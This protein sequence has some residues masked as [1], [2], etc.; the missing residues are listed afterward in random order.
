MDNSQHIEQQIAHFKQALERL[1]L[2]HSIGRIGTF[3]RSLQDNSSLWTPELEAI[4]GLNPGEFEGRHESW[5][6]YIH[7]ADRERAAHALEQAIETTGSFETEFRIIRTDQQI[8]WIQAKG[9]V[10]YDEAQQPQRMIGVQIDITERKQTALQL[11]F[12]AALLQAS[13]D[14]LIVQDAQNRVLFWNRGATVL[15]GWS[16]EEVLGQSLAQL[17][18][19]QFPLPLQQIHTLLSHQPFWEGE[20]IQTRRDGTQLTIASRWSQLHELKTGEV[21]YLIINRDISEFKR[22]QTH[23]HF[24]AEASKQLVTAQTYQEALR[25]TVHSAVPSIADWCRIDLLDSHSLFERLTVA[26]P[27]LPEE[28]SSQ[29]PP[30]LETVITTGA[31]RLFPHLSAPQVQELTRTPE[32]ANR[33][34]TQGAVSAM[35]VPFH[36][37]NVPIGILT[38]M[39]TT[40]KRTYTQTDLTMAEELASRIALTLEKVRMIQ[41]A[42][43]LNASLEAQVQH[44]TEALQ[45]SYEQLRQ[46]NI[47]LQQ[48]NQELQ[49]F[50]HVASHDLQEP[51]R[52]ILAFG[53]LLEEECGAKL[54]DGKIYLDRMRSA[55]SRMQRLIND[56][57]AFTGIATKV[58]PF[59]PVD[60]NETAQTVLDLLETRLQETGGQVQLSPL[61]TIEADPIHMQQLLQNLISNALK[62]H[63]PSIPPLVTVSATISGD[64][65]ICT[66]SVSDNGIGFDEKYL[67][68]IFTVFQRLH[69]RTEYEGTGIGLAVVRKIVERHGG[70]IT[71]RSTPGEGTTF[72]VQLPVRQPSTANETELE[73][74]LTTGHLQL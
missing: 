11:E 55:A 57:L 13:Y 50:A 6:Q 68:R 73:P 64:P 43:A 24:L 60:L 61:P 53:D 32:E 38:F 29:L 15:Y 17:L 3:E 41:H 31:S 30:L 26:F 28:T 67:D 66:L 56:L 7:P 37:Q 35:I 16:E 74:D 62:F 51:L 42:R 45:R 58:Q 70:T 19:T 8:R 47:D 23:I 48:S 71:A 36:L 44:R 22:T 54:D 33:L 20:L 9:R 18:Q 12:Q 39:I 40:A 69:G 4:Y 52:K 25:N 65:P 49:E 46:V 72:L 34:R 14:A 1:T 59:T 5:L 10:L 27:E 63:K 2:S 21:T